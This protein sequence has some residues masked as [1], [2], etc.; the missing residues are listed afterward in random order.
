MSRTLGFYLAAACCVLLVGCSDKIDPHSGKS[1]EPEARAPEPETA[2]IAPRVEPWTVEVASTQKS[3]LCTLDA[4]NGQSAT[5]N[6]FTA[7]S[8]QSVTFEGW[9]ATSNLKVPSAVQV[10]LV[11]PSSFQVI[12]TP[13]QTRDDVAKAYATN[14]LMRAGF[15]FTVPAASIPA[16]KY[17][18]YVAHADGN[19]PIMCEAN[20]TLLV[21]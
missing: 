18:L 14:D 3:Q 8:G 16:G 5:A 13:D 6:Q 21:Q 12:G 15:K 9:A 11:G 19:A 4:V 7:A 20:T 17:Q 2:A 1:T 10:V